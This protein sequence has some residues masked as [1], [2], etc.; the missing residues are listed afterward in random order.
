[1]FYLTETTR[2]TIKLQRSASNKCESIWLLSL[3][4]SLAFISYP[5]LNIHYFCLYFEYNIEPCVIKDN[6][7]ELPKKKKKKKCPVLRKNSF[8]K[9][10]NEMSSISL[11]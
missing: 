6:L 7:N 8:V 10:L 4:Q 5:E 3:K 1:M 9:S 2:M 11:D